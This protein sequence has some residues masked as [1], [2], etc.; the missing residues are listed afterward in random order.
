MTSEE[1]SCEHAH[2][3]PSKAYDHT[4]GAKAHQRQ[5]R[6]CCN[7]TAC[8]F[9]NANSLS[10]RMSALVDGIYPDTCSQCRNEGEPAHRPVL[11]ASATPRALVTRDEGVDGEGE[12]DDRH[13]DEHS[14]DQNAHILPQKCK[15][16]HSDYNGDN[17]I[18]QEEIY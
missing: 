2:P 12:Q 11:N 9:K 8:K 10:Q 7:N 18:P 13:G 14:K 16:Y 5:G 3:D 15:P 4:Q 6:R 17:S 1:Q